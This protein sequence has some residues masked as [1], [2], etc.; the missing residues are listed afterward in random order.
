MTD[1]Y[2]KNHRVY[3]RWAEYYLIKHDYSKAQDMLN[4]GSKISP[5]DID[6]RTDQGVL[7]ANTGKRAEAERILVGIQKNTSEADRLQGELFI[8]A[9]LGNNEE[10]LKALFRLAETHAWPPLVK[11]LPVFHEIRKDRRFPEFCLKVG[12]PTGDS[13]RP[14]RSK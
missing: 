1:L 8:H 12:L 13:N 10:S 4:K 7:F 6:V 11:S 5:D 9:A 3:A 2:P 14:D